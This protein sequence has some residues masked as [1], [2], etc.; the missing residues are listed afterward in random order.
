MGWCGSATTMGAP[1]LMEKVIGPALQGRY[2]ATGCSRSDSISL[3][4]ISAPISASLTRTLSFWLVTWRSFLRNLI[5]FLAE[6]RRATSRL[7][8]RK[9]ISLASMAAM[10]GPAMAIPVST[11]M[12]WLSVRVAAMIAAP[13]L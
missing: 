4:E 13:T 7:V 10:V 12:Y 9:M 6:R 8:I 3:S 1:L 11:T 5:K 2:A